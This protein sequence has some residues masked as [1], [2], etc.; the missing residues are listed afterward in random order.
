MGYRL[1][2][3][4]GYRSSCSGLFAPGDHVVLTIESTPTDYESGKSSG[5]T[6]FVRAVPPIT[7]WRV[8]RKFCQ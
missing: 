5:S 6:S 2:S 4:P 3:H 7:G 1:R 8:I